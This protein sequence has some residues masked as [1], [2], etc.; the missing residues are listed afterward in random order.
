MEAKQNNLAPTLEEE[1]QFEKLIAPQAS[2]RKHEIISAN[3]ITF[4]YGHISALYGLYL[5]FSSAKWATI[6]MAY[7]I[8]IAAE[9]GVTAGAHRLWTHRAYKAKRPLQIILMVMNSFAFQNSAIT[10]IRDH[11]MHH[12][13]SDTD[14]DPHNATRGFF[15]SHIGWLLVRKHPEVK[16]RGKTIDMSDI[17]SNPV[18]VFQKK[19]AI[20]FIGAVCFV[21][22]TLV[23]IYFWGETLTNAWHITLLRYIISL[24]VTFLVNSAA[25]LWGTRAYD[26]R[27]FPAQN[28]IVSLLAVGEGFHNY[29]HVFPWDYRTAELG[30]NYL[31]LTTKFID[32]FAWLGWAYDLK[33]VP[34]SAVQSRAARTGDGTNSW[35]WP[36]EDANEDILKQTSTL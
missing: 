14:A 22:P 8:L 26:K 21:I 11:R 20:P 12:R 35:G 16:R 23:P 13:Y 2:D 18:L 7:V 24:H 4:A 15:Y 9:V 28:L 25:H 31:N 27:I 1:A 33:S 3:L 29:H 30:N 34:D 19:Y 5:C 36:E 17:Y 6:I 32:F 10:W